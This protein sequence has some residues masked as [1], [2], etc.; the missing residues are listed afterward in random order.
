MSSTLAC[1]FQ[2]PPVH[3]AAHMY[4]HSEM[5]SQQSYSNNSYLLDS[6]LPADDIDVD[7][8]SAVCRNAVILVIPLFFIAIFHDQH[9]QG[10]YD[11]AGYNRLPSGF[12][13]SQFEE[14]EAAFRYNQMR[15]EN[16]SDPNTSPQLLCPRPTLPP[17][18]FSP[19]FSWSDWPSEPP[20]SAYQTCSEH[21]SS[22]PNHPQAAD[23]SMQHSFQ[24]QQAVMVIH[25]FLSFSSD[26]YIDIIS[27]H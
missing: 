8:Y 11:E 12:G 2:A 25:S 19:H 22:I 15:N 13:P 26:W 16:M 18:Q 1:H 17:S 9:S 20:I 3:A 27:V 14:A 5:E 4:R 7:S 23:S 6:R 10:F 24:G 21:T